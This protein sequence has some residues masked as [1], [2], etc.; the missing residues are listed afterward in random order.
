VIMVLVL[1]LNCE[2]LNLVLIF[3][4]VCFRDS[5][6]WMFLGSLVGFI[7]IHVE[8]YAYFW[9]VLVILIHCWFCCMRVVVWA[10]FWLFCFILRI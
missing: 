10:L 6:I 5:G 3:L 8:V 2:V 4:L 7:G 9:W 1:F